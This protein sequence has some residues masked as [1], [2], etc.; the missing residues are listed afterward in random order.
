M[1]KNETEM[2]AYQI[3]DCAARID[4]ESFC[5]TRPPIGPE[6]LDVKEVD[7]SEEKK[8][9]DRAVQYQ[10]RGKLKRHPDEPELAKVCEA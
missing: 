6:W 7:G 9:V 4:L 8:C 5:I 1:N 10:L 2:L 3:A